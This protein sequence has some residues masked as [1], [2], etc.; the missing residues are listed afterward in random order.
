MIRPYSAFQPSTL[1]NSQ[2]PNRPPRP[3]RPG[4]TNHKHQ[5]QTMARRLASRREADKNN[6]FRPGRG[7]GWAGRLR[8]LVMRVLVTGV[9]GTGKSSLIKE[10]RRRGYSAFDADDDGFT[11]PLPDGT[12]AWRME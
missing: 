5:T 12:W 4:I 8:F 1:T 10:L 2:S 9:S 7:A 6:L 11:A 3:A